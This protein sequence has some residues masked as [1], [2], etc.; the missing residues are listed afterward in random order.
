M[1]RTSVADDRWEEPDDLA[2]VRSGRRHTVTQR[3]TR[4]TADMLLID[5]LA[6]DAGAAAAGRTTLG[7]AGV[8][9]FRR[10]IA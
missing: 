9:D 4:G 7:L 8:A 6:R 1:H 10:N 3:T 2:D 5:N